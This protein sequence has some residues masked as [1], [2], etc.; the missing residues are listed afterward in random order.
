VISFLIPIPVVGTVIGAIGGGAL[1][2]FGGAYLGEAWKGREEEHR[3]AVG[4]SA[5]IG[6]LFGTVGKLGIGAMMVVVAAA[7]SLI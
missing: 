3:L 2:S 6:R 1:G 4:K 7:D 5:L